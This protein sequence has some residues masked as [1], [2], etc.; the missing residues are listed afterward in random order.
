M[1]WTER[2]VSCCKLHENCGDNYYRLGICCHCTF[3][4]ALHSLLHVCQ[5]TMLVIGAFWG[6]RFSLSLSPKTKQRPKPPD[7]MLLWFSSIWDY[8]FGT[9]TYS[10]RTKY[11][12][13][14]VGL[15]CKIWRAHY[16]KLFGRNWFLN[17]PHKECIGIDCFGFRSMFFLKKW[18]MYGFGTLVPY[19]C[20]CIM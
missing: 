13:D 16:G 2:R 5:N 19:H 14:F 11:N 9:D 18:A 7:W 1:K 20:I 12:H 15:V 17:G 3:Q 4:Y 10:L 8:A 6:E